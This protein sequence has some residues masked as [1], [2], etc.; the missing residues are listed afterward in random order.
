MH[1]PLLPLLLGIGISSNRIAKTLAIIWRVLR[2]G[3]PIEGLVVELDSL[4]RGEET[5]GVL[6]D[7]IMMIIYRF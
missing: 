2:E 4:D 3:L 7:D 6:R 5:L 1:L